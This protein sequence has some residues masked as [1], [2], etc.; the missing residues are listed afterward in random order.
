MRLFQYADDPATALDLLQAG[1]AVE[2]EE[3]IPAFA[4]SRTSRHQ[5][6]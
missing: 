1:L 6:G 4:G 5:G 2:P 3:A